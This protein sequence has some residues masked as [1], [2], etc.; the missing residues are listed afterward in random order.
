MTRGRERPVVRQFARCVSHEVWSRICADGRS[1][2]IFKKKTGV[3]RPA[4]ARG[5]CREHRLPG[6]FG[7]VR[8]GAGATE[9]ALRVA[10]FRPLLCP[11]PKISGEC[12][13]RPSE[14]T[15]DCVL[16]CRSP[17]RS[18]VS[19]RYLDCVCVRIIIDADP[20]GTVI[21]FVFFLRPGQSSSAGLAVSTLHVG[22]VVGGKKKVTIALTISH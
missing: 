16:C 11:P 7:T 4:P 8:P 1:D 22:L 21:F 20:T 10:L 6:A 15:R 19:W 2:S 12:G 9:G 3:R 5:E 13:T 17:S 18:F 14:C